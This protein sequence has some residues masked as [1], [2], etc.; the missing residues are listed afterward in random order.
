MMRVE[1]HINARNMERVRAPGQDPDILTIPELP[2]AHRA[3]PVRNPQPGVVTGVL[4]RR[5]DAGDG[6]AP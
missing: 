4:A 3:G 2:Q 1:P 5:N 6:I